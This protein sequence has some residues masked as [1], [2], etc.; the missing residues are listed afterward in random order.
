MTP[1]WES[2]SKE[3]LVL[4]LRARDEGSG[5]IEQLLHDLRLHQAELETEI[6]E[7]RS[8]RQLLEESRARFAGL[9]DFAPLAFCTVDREGRVLDANLTAAAL[10]GV[11][12]GSLIHRQLPQ[13]LAPEDRPALER[14][15][16]Q[17]ILTKGRVTT[18]VFLTLRSMGRVPFQVVS[19]ATVDDGDCVT[20]CKTALTDISA[21]KRSEERLTLLNSASAL[22]SASFDVHETI[23]HVVQGLAPRFADVCFADVLEENGDVTRVDISCS[24]PGHE[25]LVAALKE[26]PAPWLGLR[27]PKLVYDAGVA[28]ALKSVCANHNFSEPRARTHELSSLMLIP[29]VSRER[30][31]GMLGIATA[32]PRRYAPADLAFGVDLA[33][34][35]A[36]AIDNAR[37]YHRAQRAVHARQ[38]VLSIVSHDL[39]NPLAGIALSADQLLTPTEGR[40]RRKG[41]RHVERIRR[42]VSQ[43]RRIIDDLL[44]L[45]SIDA[46]KLAVERADENVEGIVEETLEVLAP[47]AQ[48]K[49]VALVFRSAGELWALCDR[50]RTLQVLSNLA[51]NAIKYTPGGGRVEI[52]TSLR[53]GHVQLAIHDSGPGMTRS[54]LQ[55]LFERYWRSSHSEAPGRGLGLYISKQLVEAQGGRISVESQAGVGTVASFTLP[56]GTEP[57]TPYAADGRRT[58]LVV[59]DDVT[60][61]EVLCDLLHDNAYDVAS[62]TNGREALDTLQAAHTKFSLILLD[63][64]LPVMSGREVLKELR[65]DPALRGIPVVLVSG[66]EPLDELKALGAEGCLTKPLDHGT[67]LAMIGA[68]AS[69]LPH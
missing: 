25:T 57:N 33:T 62:V 1:G 48:D 47:L 16:E 14:H 32:E 12:R 38:D 29:L 65:E 6:Q 24:G 20:G 69:Q 61:R 7:L 19:T 67:L 36:M 23:A 63:M 17:C 41:R 59:E 56:S 11:D 60:L 37:L 10:L 64:K 52:E 39:K 55:H 13:L 18:E 66:V 28:P 15:F 45:G 53:D 8:S 26:R 50:N 68:T 44:D 35:A 27:E 22:L 30:T 4:A 31:F 9:Y 42:G 43:M 58:V 49:G 40:E 21:L 2:M 34:R 54:E 51:G 46:G 3:E 5:G